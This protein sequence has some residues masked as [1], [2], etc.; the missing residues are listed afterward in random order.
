M[1]IIK[2]EFESEDKAVVSAVAA[3]TDS[4]MGSKAVK[5]KSLEVVGAETVS[6]PAGTYDVA[7]PEAVKVEATKAKAKP[8]TKAKAKP[9]PVEVEEEIEETDEVEGI[10]DLDEDPAED[11]E[12][13]ADDIRAVQATKVA[14]HRATIKAKLNELGATGIKDLDPKHYRKY[15]DF[16]SKLK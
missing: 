15:F 14:Q 9:A 5:A 6:V 7:E 16:L 11:N 2:I 8:A 4:L 13:E 1:S 12:I 3:L 10:E